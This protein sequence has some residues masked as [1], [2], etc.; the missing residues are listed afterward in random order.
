MDLHLPDFV[1]RR[2]W[3]WFSAGLVFLGAVM[4]GGAVKDYAIRYR[5]Q[6]RLSRQLE[7][8]RK[9]MAEKTLRLARAQSDD[10]F[11]ELEARRNL[12]LVRPDEIEFRFIPGRTDPVSAEGS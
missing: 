8:T 7:E 9:R 11:L 1:A 2:P 3:F 10:A 12:G 4:T 5:E 6:S